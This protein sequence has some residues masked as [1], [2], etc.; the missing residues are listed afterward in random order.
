MELPTL[1]RPGVVALI[2]AGSAQTKVVLHTGGG[3]TTITP[4]SVV[5]PS[6][7]EPPGLFTVATFV[8][9]PPVA[10]TLI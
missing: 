10:V 9:V 8:I 3:G 2:G 5:G 1:Q 6:G 4:G 7:V